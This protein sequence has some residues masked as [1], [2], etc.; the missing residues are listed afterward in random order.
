MPVEK[1]IKIKDKLLFRAKSL[2]DYPLKGQFEPFLSELKQGHRRI[3]EGN[4]KI[5]YR[6]EN[7][8]IYIV[9]FFDGRVDP[10]K[11]KN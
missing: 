8:I 4:F 10:K 1:A 3:I 5:I 11:M 7:D 6:I 2:G 9:D